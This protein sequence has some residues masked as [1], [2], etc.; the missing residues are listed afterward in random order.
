LFNLWEFPS[1]ER[2]AA[3]GFSPIRENVPLGTAKHVFT[4]IV[5]FMTAYAARVSCIKLPENYR[6]TADGHGLALPSAMRAWQR[7]VFGG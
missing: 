7:L 2:L 1:E 5:W 6:W 3:D 4:H